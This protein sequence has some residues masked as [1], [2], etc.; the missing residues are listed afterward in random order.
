LRT[1]ADWKGIQQRAF[2]ARQVLAGGA[3]FADGLEYLLQQGELVRGERVHRHKLG[4]VFVSPQADRIAN[5]AEL[6]GDDVALASV[7]IAQGNMGGFGFGQ[8]ALA[9]DFIGVAAG[10]GQARVEAA[11]NLGEVL[12]FGFVGLTNG[13]VDVFLAGDDDPCPA[14]AERAQLLGDGLQGEHQLRVVADELA[15]LVDQENDAVTGGLGG[16]VV[17]DQLGEPSM[18]MR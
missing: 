5:K 7:D 12:R 16:E 1:A 18:L 9:D 10:Q 8:E 4:G 11:L 17:L 14:L 3:H 2:P 6:I 15:N 13:G